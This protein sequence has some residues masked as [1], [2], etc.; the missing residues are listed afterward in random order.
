MYTL[1]IRL[2]LIRTGEEIILKYNVIQFS[3]KNEANRYRF[4][5]VLTK[6]KTVFLK[7]FPLMLVNL[8][9]ASFGLIIFYVGKLETCSFAGR[10]KILLY[11]PSHNLGLRYI[12]SNV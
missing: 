2:N 4:S 12:N 1:K 3:P 5:G 11:W 7:R 10:V 9:A 8:V 6:K